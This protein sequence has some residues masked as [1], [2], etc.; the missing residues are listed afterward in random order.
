MGDIICTFPAALELKKRHPGA[1]FIFVCYRPFACLPRIGGVTPHVITTPFGGK[2]SR[3]L[4][5]FMF[6]AIYRFEHA[7]EANSASSQTLIEYSCRQYGVAITAA[8]PKLHI[9][10]D[11]FL[12]VKALLA[13]YKFTDD[14]IILIHPGPSWPI[15]EWPL[16]SWIALVR[17]L[18]EHGHQ[19]I[20]Q[21]GGDTLHVG[22]A[23]GV[24]IPGVVPLVNQL[25]LEESIGLISLASVFV[26]IESGLLHVAASVRT[27]AVGI[28]GPTSPQFRFSRESSCSSVVSRVDCQ[29]CHHRL[30]RLHW[31]TG[32]PNDIKCMKIIE[33]DEVLSACLSK[34]NLSKTESVPET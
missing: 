14:P 21:L 28:F 15:R 29:G 22:K 30:P 31:I 20:I 6:S 1:A 19:N 17:K 10:P 5:S 25:T 34:L 32:C 18:K 9:A 12:R 3:W 23:E 27:P 8:H 11:V 4:W 16:E 7:E 2:R 26:G 33:V 13:K 24:A